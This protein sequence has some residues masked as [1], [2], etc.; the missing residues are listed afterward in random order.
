MSRWIL[1]IFIILFST[2]LSIC[3]AE[4][5]SSIL[6]GDPVAGKAKSG[7]CA[8]CHNEDGNSTTAIWPKIAGLGQAYLL[9]QLLDFK[10]GATGLRYD[11]SMYGMVQNL[12]DQD[13]ADLAA[14]YS[15]Q[16]MLLGEAQPDKVALGQAIYRGGNLVT[17]VPACA[18]C[19]DAR[20]A[21]NY[22]AMFPRL[23]GQNSDYI[24]AQL[25][26]FKNN[27]RSNDVNGIMRDVAARM[28][29]KEIEA[30]ASYVAGL[31]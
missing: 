20:G 19:H 29:D 5:Q 30:V 4:R 8:A 25:N 7:V 18:A 31:H 27:Q 16:V 10:Q 2:S 22:L 1:T 6:R 9:Q 15:T 26:K 21:G 24:V 3:A 11:P 13:L 28:T 23:S 14:Y 17:G 12:S